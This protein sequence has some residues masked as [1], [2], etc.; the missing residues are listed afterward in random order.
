[1][2]AIVM[3]QAPNYPG[4]RIQR[5]LVDQKLALAETAA[6]EVFSNEINE[7]MR[8]A[9]EELRDA[10]EEMRVKH[11]QK[12]RMQ[13]LQQKQ[14]VSDNITHMSKREYYELFELVKGSET[15]HERLRKGREERE[16]LYAL[17]LNYKLVPNL[18][19]ELDK[20]KREYSIFGREAIMRSAGSS[21]IDPP[22]PHVEKESSEMA[23]RK[24]SFIKSFARSTGAEDVL[25]DLALCFLVPLNETSRLISKLWRKTI[26]KP[27]ERLFPPEVAKGHSRLYWTCVSTSLIRVR[28]LTLNIDM[29]RALIR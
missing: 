3:F 23:S 15:R 12:E 6:G 17:V 27:F 1:M 19:N 25:V 29:W 2:R 5:E 13:A 22:L 28:T 26:G 21:S 10:E 4:L 20:W 7:R 9:E 14:S 11:D 18:E 16:R 8:E 24:T